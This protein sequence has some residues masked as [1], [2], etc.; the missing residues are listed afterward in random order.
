MQD[1]KLYLSFF[2]VFG[3]L[4]YPTND[5]DDRGK[6]DAKA[7]IGIFVGYTPAKKAFRIYNKRTRK[8]IETIHVTFDELTVMASEQFSLG[9][10]LYFVTPATSIQEAVAPRATVLP[11]FLLSTSIDQDAP[12]TSGVLKNKVRLVAQGFRQEE[13][14]DFEESFIPVARIEAIRIFIENAAHKNM[15]IFQMDVKTAFLNGKLKEEEPLTWASVLEGYR[16]S[17]T[18]YENADHAGCQDTRRSASGSTQ[19]LGDK[20]VSWSSKKQKEILRICPKI[21]GQEFEDLP[22]EHDILSFIRDIGYTKEITYLTDV[23]L[24]YLHQLCRAFSTVINKCLSGKETR[25]DKIHLSHLQILLEKA[26][27]PKYI[28][29][30]VDSDTSPKQKPVQATKGTRIKTK[31]KVAKSD[32][33]KQP[34]KMTKAKGL[35]VLSKIALTEAKELKLATKRSKNQDF[36]KIR[37]T[38]TRFIDDQQ[39]CRHQEVQTKEESCYVRFLKKEEAVGITKYDSGVRDME[40]IT[41]ACNHYK[42]PTELEIQEMVNILVSWEEYNIVFKH[43][44][45]LHAPFEVRSLKRFFT[46]KDFHISHASGSGDGVDTQSKDDDED[47]FEVDAD[48]ND[49]DSDDND[50]SDDERTEFDR[51][52]IPDPNLT[53]V[54]QTEHEEEDVD[55]RVQTPSDYELTND[56]KIHDEENI[57]KE[58]E[59]EV[60][61][62]LYDDV[63]VNLGNEDSEMI[64]VDQGDQ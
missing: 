6:L 9:P 10:G 31:A 7:D 15:T 52:E 55:E 18:T 61:K 44:D 29:K 62:E 43:L 24:G 17:L 30:K 8:I 19:F 41:A 42:E 20:L 39:G 33:K 32:K 48:N 35:D 60:T 16:W 27:K 3:A 59:D 36:L 2:H 22:L 34:A 57:N 13:G 25:M 12:S 58:E 11:N 28:R 50:K 38:N 14:I 63:N 1:E 21:L 54:D 53:N 47:D 40:V 51:Y 37:Y 4:R 23:N 64:N 49:D 26:P 46:K 45:M 56:E 5:N